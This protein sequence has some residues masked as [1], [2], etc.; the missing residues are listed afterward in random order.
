MIAI[1]IKLQVKFVTIFKFQLTTEP[2]FLYV[3]L[4]FDGSIKGTLQKLVKNRTN[5]IWSNTRA[6]AYIRRNPFIS[7]TREVQLE[8]FNWL[9]NT[10]ISLVCNQDGNWSMAASSLPSCTPKLCAGLIWFWYQQIL[11]LVSMFF[12]FFYP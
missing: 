5:S 4:S 8:L 7:T 10:S 3:K 9:Q 1:I 2:S 12:S 6:L 11:H